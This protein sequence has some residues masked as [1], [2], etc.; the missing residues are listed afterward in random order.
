MVMVLFSRFSREKQNTQCD[1]HLNRCPRHYHKSE[2]GNAERDAVRNRKD[3]NGFN[4][5]PPVAGD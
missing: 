5:Q 4:Q 1:Y 2:G 3:A